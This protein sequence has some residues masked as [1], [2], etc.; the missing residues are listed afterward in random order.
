M[1][2]PQRKLGKFS[3][4]KP[5]P[6]ITQAKFI[7]LTDKLEK[8]KCSQP[9]AIVEVRRLAEMGDFSENHAYQMAKGRLRGI[10]Q[11]IL[12]IKD[13]LKRAEIIPESNT[14]GIIE[15]GSKIVVE[16]GGEIKTFQLLGS[17]ETNPDLGIISHNSRVG[18]A[19]VGA[20]I[21]DIVNIKL[22]NKI[23]EYK[24]LKIE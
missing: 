4:L 7:E 20:R 8:L 15:L 9:H 1:Q 11:R 17:S 19:L 3:H 2:T 18:Q 12:D 16:V 6:C 14:T 13:H 5:D 10:N 23:I 21:G 24:I 22:P